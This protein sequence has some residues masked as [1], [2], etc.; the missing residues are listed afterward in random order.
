M[1]K[2]NLLIS[3]VALSLSLFL[4]QITA[5]AKTSQVP[6]KTTITDVRYKSHPTYTRVV[7]DCDKPPLYRIDRML[8]SHL[9]SVHF[10]NAIL[11]QLLLDTPILLLQGSLQTLETKE[12][13]EDDVV[14]LLTFKNPGKHKVSALTNPNRL[15]ID[16]TNPIEEP[17]SPKEELSPM[18]T[19]EPPSAP[20][21]PKTPSSPSLPQGSRGSSSSEILTIIIDPGHGGEDTGAIGQRGLTESEIVLDVSIRVVRLL[22]ERLRKVVI[23]TRDT[24]IF[25]PLKDR[26]ELANNKNADLFVSIHANAARRKTAH[27]IETYLFGRATDAQALEVAARENATDIKSAQGFQEIIL[28]DL[29]RD[30]VL[31]EALEL[32]HY[33]QNAFV[34]TLIPRYPT[35]SLGVK[36]APFYVL[37]HTKMPAILAEISFVSNKIEE[38]RLREKSYRQTIAE[39]IFQGIKEYIEAKRNP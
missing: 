8:D 34:K 14:V 1:K 9:I 31:N 35:A 25:I 28:N 37:A 23:M 26:T 11:G 17:P 29:L 32:A 36:K 24:D 22:R 21:P 27:G 6:N 30:F 5:S 7:I 39:S 16:V 20:E 3:I 19:P 15:V 38:E 4:L 12:D 13:G 2:Q 18:P 10:S 33:T